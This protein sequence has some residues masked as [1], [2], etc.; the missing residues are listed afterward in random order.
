MLTRA[1]QPNLAGAVQMVFA[2]RT[3]SDFV[4]PEV[5]QCLE[6]WTGK[7]VLLAMSRVQI[8]TKV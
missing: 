4:R 6:E 2:N 7:A 5:V 3:N 1:R 8:T